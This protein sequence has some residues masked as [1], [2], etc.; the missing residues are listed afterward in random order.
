MTAPP[1]RTPPSP[2][3]TGRIYSDDES[4]G[5]LGPGMPPD[6]QRRWEGPPGH[7][8]RL[9]PP[10]LSDHQRACAKRHERVGEIR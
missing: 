3:H 8:P 5:F 9:G 6:R 2:R 4:P 7:Q 1:G 10:L